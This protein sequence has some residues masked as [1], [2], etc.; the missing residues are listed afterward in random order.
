[1]FGGEHGIALQSMQGNQ[2]SS[3]GEGDVSWF[4]SRC[5]R[6]L[7]YILLLQRGCPF[8]TQVC[9]ATSGLLSSY[10]GHLRNLH[11]AWHCNKDA[12]RDEAGDSGS[13]S[14]SHRDIRIP[15]N[16]QEESGIISF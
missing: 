4:F 6:N 14:I 7:G 5:S 3:H 15:V 11:K 9:T 2:A 1:M 16:F 8:K 10:K 12:S 13:L